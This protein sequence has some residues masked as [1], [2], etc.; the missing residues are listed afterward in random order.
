MLEFHKF[1]DYISYLKVQYRIEPSHRKNLHR[2]YIVDELETVPPCPNLSICERNLAFM[3][4][5]GNS[6]IQLE[7][8]RSGFCFDICSHPAKMGSVDKAKLSVRVGRKVKDL[9]G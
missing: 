2:K 8:A 7:I 5:C 6:R 9:E 4:V 3:W 1:N